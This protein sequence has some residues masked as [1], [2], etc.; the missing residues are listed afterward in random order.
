MM[1]TEEVNSKSIWERFISDNAPQSF[2]QSWEWGEVIKVRNQNLQR[3][4]MYNNGNLWGVAQIETV[5]AKRGSYLH[6]RHGPVTKDWNKTNMSYLISE[7][8]SYAQ[9][10]KALFIRVSPL[11]DNSPENNLKFKSF[12]FTNAPI[13]AMDGE[14]CWVLDIQ[15]NESE[16]LSGMRK[17][18]RN[19][20]KQAIKSRVKIIK[21]EDKSDLS[22]FFR[23]YEDTAKRH[24]F[25]K[26]KSISEEFDILSKNRNIIMLKGYWGQVLLSV[27]LVIFYNHQA[28]YHHSAS[29]PQ[30]IPVNYLLQWEAILEAKRRGMKLYNFWGIAPFEKKR[31]PWK[32]LTMFKTGFGGELKEYMHAKDLPCSIKYCATYIIDTLRKISKGY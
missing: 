9:K 24:K 15:K 12:G 3:L 30:K 26:H 29:V 8:R 10:N 32:G 14:Y 5:R 16:L 22:E 19:L 21:S 17:T 4:G 18:T 11:I 6:V 25:V 23:L 13:H 27:A 7:L 28:I 20:I 2:F 1:K 31:H